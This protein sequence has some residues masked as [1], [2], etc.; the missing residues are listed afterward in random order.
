MN[1]FLQT[2]S[3]VNIA[4][5]FKNGRVATCATADRFREGLL[6]RLVDTCLWA[7]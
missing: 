6:D 4:V 2:C 1:A 7:A 5:G 3:R